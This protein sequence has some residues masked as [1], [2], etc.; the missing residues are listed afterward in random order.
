MIEMDNRT[1]QK[2]NEL[3]YVAS[4]LWTICFTSSTRI[5]MRSKK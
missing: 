3:M 2:N 4:V 5:R 1:L